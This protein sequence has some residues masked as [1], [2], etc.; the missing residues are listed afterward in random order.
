MISALLDRLFPSRI[1]RRASATAQQQPRMTT[2]A[3]SFDAAA[4]RERAMPD[5]NEC[6]PTYCLVMDPHECRWLA[7]QKWAREHPR[8]AMRAKRKARA[9]V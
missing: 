8:L 3:Q 6:N 9:G 7:A 5:L 4:D 2:L 1:L